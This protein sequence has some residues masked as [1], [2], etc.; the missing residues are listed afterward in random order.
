[1]ETM[2]PNEEPK[3][4]NGVA[5]TVPFSEARMSEVNSADLKNTFTTFLDHEG[6]DNFAGMPIDRQEIIEDRFAKRY[7]RK[8]GSSG[9]GLWGRAM[10]WLF[11]ANVKR[12]LRSAHAA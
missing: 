6:I 9:K 11:A 5:E 1:M 7:A 8:K 10:E 2:K 4:T 3:L 12:Q